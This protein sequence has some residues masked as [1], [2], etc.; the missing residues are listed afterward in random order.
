[1]Y[2]QNEISSPKFHQ[3]L[4]R[5]SSP[6]SHQNLGKVT[7]T[8][9]QES[10]ARALGHV[11]RIQPTNLSLELLRLQIQG[12]WDG[13]E[14]RVDLLKVNKL[15]TKPFDVSCKEGTGYFIICMQ[16]LP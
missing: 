9:S 14:A 4:I 6:K 3:N 5:I 12:F 1:M 8:P 11:H 15:F 16:K 2:Q 10:S 7:R 13:H